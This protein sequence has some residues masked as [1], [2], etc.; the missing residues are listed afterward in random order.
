MVLRERHIILFVFTFGATGAI[1]IIH[2]APYFGR[3][4]KKMSIEGVLQP[5][6]GFI[7]EPGE[8]AHVGASWLAVDDLRS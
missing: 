2:L 7:V 8:D 5:R 1:F 6:T 3:T 4:M